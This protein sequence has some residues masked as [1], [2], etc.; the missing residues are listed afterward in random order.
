[1]ILHVG[2]RGLVSAA[3]GNPFAGRVFLVLALVFAGIGA[4]LVPLLAELLSA[5]AGVLTLYLAFAAWMA[6]RQREGGTTNFLKAA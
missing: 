5:G 1:M 3:A 6:K 4:A 2:I